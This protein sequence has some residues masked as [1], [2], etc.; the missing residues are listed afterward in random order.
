MQVLS[1]ISFLWSLANGYFFNGIEGVRIPCC[2]NYIQM[3]TFYLVHVP[4]GAS[5]FY[6]KA[7]FCGYHSI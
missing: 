2:A 1:L 5:S 6:F 3:Q 4:W 7:P